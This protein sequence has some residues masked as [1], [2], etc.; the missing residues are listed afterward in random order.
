MTT[1]TA[2]YKRTFSPLSGKYFYNHNNCNTHLQKYTIMKKNLLK[3]MTA[4]IVALFIAL[5]ALPQTAL[6]QSKEAY[7]VENGST[8]TFYYDA[9]KV[10]RSGTKYGIDDKR[11][12]DT[13]VPAWAGSKLDKNE[14]TTKVVFDSSFKK[15]RPTTTSCWFCICKTLA[16][17]EGIE[18]LYTEEVTDMSNM[19]LGCSSL[20]SIDVTK[21]NTAK[22]TDMRNM[23]A[24]CSALTTI[25]C[26]DNWNRG[27]VKES[28]GMF[29]GS[30]NLKGFATYDETRTDV[31]MANPS[32]GY[33]TRKPVAYVV[34]NGSTLTFYYDTKKETRTGNVYDIS[35]LNWTGNQK[36][37]NTQIKTVVFD[38]SFK[39][40]RPTTTASWFDCCT[41]IATIKSMENL[42]T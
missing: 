6:A 12:D 34:E 26:Y 33:F 4:A 8:L 23:F 38:S 39:D 2:S 41:M 35:T 7:V 20:T 19:F 40:Y 25:Y 28:T 29:I 37:P 14:R 32:S 16:T 17:I 5:L 22:V 3:N 13:K 11:T 24:S 27:V 42:N 15:Y 36:Q 9:S 10:L 30:R 31:S 1:A 18:N 21:F